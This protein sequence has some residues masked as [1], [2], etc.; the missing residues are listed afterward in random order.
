MFPFD[1]TKL[2][3]IKSYL[4]WCEFARIFIVVS[5]RNSLLSHVVIQTRS[6][7]KFVR[8]KQKTKKQQFRLKLNLLNYRQPNGKEDL[9]HFLIMDKSYSANEVS[10]S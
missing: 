1:V 5:R 8:E 4:I 9:H 2:T 6:E 7:N 10:K 3:F